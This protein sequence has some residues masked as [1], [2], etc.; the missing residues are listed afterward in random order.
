M[1]NQNASLFIT[2]LAGIFLGSGL[3]YVLFGNNQVQ[4]ESGLG[5]SNV[6]SQGATPARTNASKSE[7]LVSSAPKTVRAKPKKAAV[8]EVSDGEAE[9]LMGSVEVEEAD[10]QVGEGVILGHV[11]NMDGKPMAGVIVRLSGSASRNSTASPAKVGRGAPDRPSLKETVRKAAQGYHER[12]TRN[13]ETTTDANGDYR[14]EELADLSWGMSAY[15]KDH[16][17]EADGASRRLRVGSEMDFIAKPIV[18]V[19]VQVLMPDG[20]QPERA[21][22]WLSRKGRNNRGRTYEWTPDEAFL[23]VVPGRYVVRAYSYDER[24]NELAEFASKEQKLQVKLGEQPAEIS[25]ELAPRLSITGFLKAAKGFHNRN[26]CRIRLLALTE[27]QELDLK[28]LKDSET[29]EWSQIGSRF[30]FSDLEPGRYAIGIG[31]E[32]SSPIIDHEIVELVDKTIEVDLELPAVDFSRSLTVLAQDAQGVPIDDVDFRFKVKKGNGS[33]TNGLQT[34][35]DE[36]AGYTITIPGEYEE[37]YFAKGEHTSEYFL[38]ASHSEY[39]STEIELTPG[40]T[41][42]TITFKVPGSLAI[43]I[44]GYLGSGREGRVALTAEKKGRE[45]NHYYFGNE[46]GNVDVDGV[47]RLE[48][49]EPGLYLVSM[50][51]MPVKSDDH[52]WNPGRKVN[53]AEFEVRGGE[54]HMNLALPALYDLRVHWSEATEGATLHL[55]SKDAADLPFGFGNTAFDSNQV[56]TWHDLPAGEYTLQHYAGESQVMDVSVPCGELEFVPK[57]VNAMRV[58]ISDPEGDLAKV[59]FQE[60]DVIIGADGKEFQT[61]ADLTNLGQRLISKGSNVEVMVLRGNNHLTIN[62]TGDSIDNWQSMGGQMSPT[63]R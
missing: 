56:I 22:I 1:K 32:W 28:T 53:S 36:E 4:A 43:S 14:F 47:C 20:M 34:T 61:Q 49:L 62:V 58:S 52:S 29:T 40:Q 63:S 37:D 15:L 42:A 24:G 10:A 26:S 25:I 12:K 38:K 5:M 19:P 8:V 7:N 27:D 39:G 31:R 35:P 17:V 45:G 23:R 11:A 21:V 50:T 13:H 46:Q 30:T 48:G 59:G 16:L 41:E 54:N 44:P 57:I 55:Q 9:R 6:E 51:V 18:E 33:S 2:L 3:G 60:G